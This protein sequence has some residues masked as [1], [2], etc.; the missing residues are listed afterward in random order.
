VVV[1]E[2]EAATVAAAFAVHYHML[3]AIVLSPNCGC[4]RT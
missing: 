2:D 1:W 3:V 4:P